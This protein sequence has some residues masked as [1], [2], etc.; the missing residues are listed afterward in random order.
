M[1]RS[2]GYPTPRRRISVLCVRALPAFARHR[3]R[4]LAFAGVPRA[5][6]DARQAQRGLAAGATPADPHDGDLHALYGHQ[7]HAHVV[8]VA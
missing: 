7:V 2:Q 5:V 8:G 4:R 1:R 6:I 3:L